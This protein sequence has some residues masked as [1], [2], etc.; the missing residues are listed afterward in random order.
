MV[1]ARDRLREV[2]RRLG[3]LFTDTQKLEQALIH[4]SYANEAGL[5]AYHNERLEFLGDSIVGLVATEF[6]VSRYEETIR[7]GE[8]S[9]YKSVLIST[10]TLAEFARDIGLGDYLLLG[11][12]EAQ[13]GGGQKESVL[14]NGFEAVI[15][16]CYLDQGLA[17]VRD[18]LLPRMTKV[19]DDLEAR[20][21]RKDA[22]TLLKEWAQQHGHRRVDY[23]LLSRE[24]P[25]HKP[26]FLT[27]VSIDGSSYGRGRAGTKLASQVDAARRALRRLDGPHGQ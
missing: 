24:G 16:A 1:I 20:H 13:S 25:E 23:R 17:A 3:M 9:R 10:S 22:K 2:G 19:Q 27:E 21:F 6:L 26:L 11:R 7:E 5:G 4:T 12:G 15:A 8:L 14:A 18:Y